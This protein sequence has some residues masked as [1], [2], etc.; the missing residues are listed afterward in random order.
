MRVDFTR[1]LL[2][3]MCRVPVSMCTA[4]RR[5]DASFVSRGR[6]PPVPEYSVQ[7]RRRLSRA[8]SA[9]RSVGRVTTMAK[10]F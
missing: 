5:R 10:K 6:G 3:A 9:A 8:H 2:R 4:V 1:S 7:R